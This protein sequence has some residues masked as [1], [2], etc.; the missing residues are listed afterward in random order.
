MRKELVKFYI[1]DGVLFGEQQSSFSMDLDIAKTLIEIR[2]KINKGNSY[3]AFFN[4][5]KLEYINKDA[6]EFMINKGSEGLIAVA[7]FSTNNAS[8]MIINAFLVVYQPKIPTK[9]FG[10]KEKALIWLQQ[11]VEQ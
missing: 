5:S 6:R 11:Y 10:N 1:K 7:F 9:M 8:R 4:F 2:L 3:P